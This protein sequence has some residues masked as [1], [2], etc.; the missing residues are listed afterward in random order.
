MQLKSKWSQTIQRSVATLGGPGRVR[1]KAY[2]TAPTQCLFI[3]H[4]VG[5]LIQSV[6]VCDT[7]NELSIIVRAHVSTICSVGKTKERELRNMNVANTWAT[8][9]VQNMGE[10]KSKPPY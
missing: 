9:I 2:D 6:D 4:T 8:K 7:A 10:K 3:C 5:S 1:E